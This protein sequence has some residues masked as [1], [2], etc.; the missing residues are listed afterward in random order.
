[1]GHTKAYTKVVLN[2]SKEILGEQPPEA[3]IG[4]CVK[5]MVTEGQKWHISGYII[6]ANPK[7]IEAEKDYFEKLEKTK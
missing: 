1:M 4:K 6:D 5:I 3:F 7:L 2:T